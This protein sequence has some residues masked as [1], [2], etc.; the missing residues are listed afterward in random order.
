MDQGWLLPASVHDFVLSGLQA[1]F[2]LDA[3]RKGLD[4]SAIFHIHTEDRGYPAYH[5]GRIVA[6]HLYGYSRG[7]YSSRQLTRTCEARVDVMADQNLT[8]AGTPDDSIKRGNA[9]AARPPAPSSCRRNA[10]G[11]AR[12]VSRRG[13]PV[14]PV[15]APS[16]PRRRPRC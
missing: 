1:H 3:A 4:L 13:A 9:R 11:A 14:P 5:P 2:V 6:L 16:R 7:L 10:P 8:L 12:P 15:D